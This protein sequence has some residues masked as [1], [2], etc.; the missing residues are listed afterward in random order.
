MY[1]KQKKMIG[2]MKEILQEDYM[3][4]RVVSYTHTEHL[5]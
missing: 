3:N 5:D 1:E 2:L 4:Q